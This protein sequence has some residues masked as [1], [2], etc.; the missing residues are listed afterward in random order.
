[1][2]WL[3]EKLRRVNSEMWRFYRDSITA[4]GTYAHYS[5]YLE[6]LS[7]PPVTSVMSP[8]YSPTLFLVCEC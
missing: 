1:M 2:C 3:V 7:C 6:H 5:L 8:S 4:P